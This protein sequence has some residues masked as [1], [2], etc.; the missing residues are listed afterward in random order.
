MIQS[1]ISR[2]W[3]RQSAAVI[4]AVLV[5]VVCGG[6]AEAGPKRARL[7]RDLAERLSNADAGVTSVIVSGSPETLEALATRYGAK[8]KKTLYGAA[9]LEVNGGQ[10]DALSQDPEVDHLSGDVPVTR[11]GGEAA[12]ATGADQLWIGATKKNQG[13]TGAGI[14]VAVIDSGIAQTPDLNSRVAV[15]VD[16]TGTRSGNGDPYGHG[17]HVA[18]IIAGGNDAYPGIAP[19]ATLVNLRVIGADGSGAT[20]DVIDAINWAIAH[21]VQFNLRVINLSLGHPV[22]EAAAD[23]PLCVAVQHAVDEGIVVVVA[24]GNFGKMPDGTPIVGGT[25]SPGNAAAALTIGALNTKGTPERSDDVMATYSS[26]GPTMFEGLVKPE[27]VAPG[28]RIVSASSDNSYFE[29]VYPEWIVQGKGKKAYI[30]MSGTSMSTAVVSGAVALLL[31]AMPTLSPAEVKLLLQL[32]S[33]PVAGA[34]LIEAGAGSLNIAAAMQLATTGN[35]APTTIAGE[36][37]TGRGD[38][39]RE[40]W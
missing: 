12:A 7:S 15:T 28:N 11:M 17:T 39:V 35:K 5:A 22:M 40:G 3:R 37:V 24:A 14:G 4:G 10:L 26:R 8:V 20:S 1:L 31:Q 13:F 27:L 19:G 38:R 30:E 29:Q 6:S 9:V 34:G 23:D 18:G 33:S 25:H 36:T 16:F 2:A 21:R 32:T